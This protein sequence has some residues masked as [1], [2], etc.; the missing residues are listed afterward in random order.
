MKIIEFLLLMK[1]LQLK[2][3]DYIMFLCI[4]LHT[5]FWRPLHDV[6]CRRVTSPAVQVC[7]QGG[8]VS[9]LLSALPHPIPRV[10]W[11]GLDGGN[12]RRRLR[13]GIGLHEYEIPSRC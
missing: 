8:R 10:M 6:D 3:S 2:K 13:E 5:V 7:D 4:K 11:R 1:S 12:P 9:V